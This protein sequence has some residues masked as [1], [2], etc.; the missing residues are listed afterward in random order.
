[1]KYTAFSTVL[2]ARAM[3]VGSI[4]WVCPTAAC[5]NSSLEMNPENTGM[6]TM[7]REPT[8]NATPA[9]RLRNPA[10]VMS[11]YLS[12]PP[13]ASASPAAATNSSDLVAP[14]ESTW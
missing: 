10:P 9:R 7:D 8:V 3:T 11:P 4:L 13:E 5:A 6:P 1:M 14:W 12:L 2:I